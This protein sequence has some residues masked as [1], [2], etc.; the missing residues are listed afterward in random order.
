MEQQD[1]TE[2]A[3]VEAVREAQLQLPSSEYEKPRMF[4][5]GS[6]H[7]VTRGSSSSGS[8]DANSQYYW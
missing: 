3:R 7:E 4:K 2:S 1:S 5:I 8:S 6:V